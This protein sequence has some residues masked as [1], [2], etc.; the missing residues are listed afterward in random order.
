[1]L[2]NNLKTK[3][4]F[5]LI[6]IFLTTVSIILKIFVVSD[7]NIAFTSDQARDMIEIRH[8]VV[9]HK[10]KLI[11]P[12]TDILGLYLG[13][14][15]YYFNLIPFIFSNGNPLWLVFWQIF[16]FHLSV[17]ISYFLIQK[18]NPKFALISSILLLISPVSFLINR[19]SFNAN[20]IVFATIIFFSIYFST[21][22]KPTKYKLFFLGSI[23]G[24][25]LQLQAAFAVLLFPFT[26][27][28]NFRY[29]KKLLFFG[30][31]ITLIPQLTFEISKKFIMTRS[32]INEILGKTGYL[33]LPIGFYEKIT[34]RYE[35]LKSLINQSLY[36]PFFL[37]L[38]IFI[39][40]I[41]FVYYYSK[42]QKPNK[43]ISNIGLSL[44][45]FFVFSLI[46]Y[47]IF[48]YQ[49]KDWYLYGLT[50]PAI[51]LI[52]LFLTKIFSHNKFS[53]ITTSLLII[54]LTILSISKNLNYLNNIKNNPSSDPSNL[55]NQLDIVNAIY[56]QADDRGFSV[57]SYLPSV[58]DYT[59][60]YLFWWYGTKKYHYQ[61][62][63]ITYLPNQPEYIKDNYLFWQKTKPSTDNLTFLIIQ[64]AQHLPEAASNWLTHFSS[65]CYYSDLTFPWKV[66][67]ET[68]QNCLFQEPDKN[69]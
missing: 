50:V 33:Y 23:A 44:L 4:N 3:A 49:L 64:E 61:P 62:E 32:I 12:I 18:I 1:M 2:E 47:I 40:S 26:F 52:S 24:I 68:R 36:L 58:Y 27:F 38:I 22:S 14:F 57:Y 51:L 9:S 28:T 37:G 13:P 10:P 60:Q 17:I 55:K 8:M 69:Q 66:T 19:F 67:L 59:Y 45:S 56:Q 29:S 6:L 41:I 31:I 63:K 11:G 20:A 21:I 7:N 65:L 43:D 42:H 30:F 39:I 54:F 16:W 25:A 5:F 35:L 48:P 34:N 15:W 53:K 46:F